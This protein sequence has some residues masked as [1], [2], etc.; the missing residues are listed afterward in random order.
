MASD[1]PASQLIAK[2][3]EEKVVV[4]IRRHENTALLSARGVAASKTKHKS[5]TK[6]ASTASLC[7]LEPE[8]PGPQKW[9]SGTWMRSKMPS[10]ESK[11]I[12]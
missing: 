4:K 1:F 10:L 3:H 8:S 9:P 6:M 2:W 11:C 12:N 7:V 5:S